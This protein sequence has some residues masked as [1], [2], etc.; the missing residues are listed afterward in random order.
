MTLSVPG[1]S[2][3]LTSVG[4]FIKALN[5]VIYNYPISVTISTRYKFID[6]NALYFTTSTIVEWT[7]I[8]TR[9]M[10]KTILPDSV[11]Y[12]Q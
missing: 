9:E 7:D 3:L 6:N 10:Y 12:Y 5:K 8:F 2:L 4:F 11:I 1:K